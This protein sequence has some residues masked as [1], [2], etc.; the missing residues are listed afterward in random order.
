MCDLR[1]I[2]LTDVGGR[3]YVWKVEKCADVV[4]KTV[5][6]DSQE[7]ST[8][9]MCE[10]VVEIRLGR[11]E[12]PIEFTEP[13][14]VKVVFPIPLKESSVVGAHD[15][16]YVLLAVKSAS[17]TGNALWWTRYACHQT[18]LYVPDPIARSSNGRGRY[19]ARAHF[20]LRIINT[21]IFLQ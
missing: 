19:A 12:E 6:D 2:Q 16:T 1:S 20:I 15:S 3:E 8:V 17:S 5:D 10:E 11:D 9:T 18:S 13:R 7:D 21:R 4:L 14:T